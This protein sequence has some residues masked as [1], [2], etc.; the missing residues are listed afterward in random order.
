MLKIYLI[1]CLVVFIITVII[2]IQK[3]SIKY[4][5]LKK[6]LLGTLVMTIFSWY[7]LFVSFILLYEGITLNFK[8][9][10]LIR[11]YL[12]FLYDKIYDIYSFKNI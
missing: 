4:F 10:F 11:W 6:C 2:T 1:G 12:N 5:G 8:V 9:D 3:E 7:H